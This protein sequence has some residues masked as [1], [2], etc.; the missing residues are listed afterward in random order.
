MIVD[1]KT[2]VEF[3]EGDIFMV[4]EDISCS[5]DAELYRRNPSSKTNECFILTNFRDFG[6]A[7]DTWEFDL[8]ASID[9]ASSQLNCLNEGG[10]E[11]INPDEA[12]II[13]ETLRHHLKTGALEEVAEKSYKCAFCG[14]PIEI[15]TISDKRQRVCTECYRVQE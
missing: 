14:S 2:I 3:E 4:M 5:G 8:Y 15:V 7:D 11:G 6:A 13:E 12:F 1:G 9:D 10:D